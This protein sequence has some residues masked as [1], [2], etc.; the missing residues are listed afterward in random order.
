MTEPRCERTDLPVSMCAHCRG[1]DHTPDGVRFGTTIAARYPGRCALCDD[2]IEPDDLI[3][4]VLDD[5][6]GADGWACTAC[7]DA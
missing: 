7:V 2:H 6:G 5:H 4:V 3:A 1:H